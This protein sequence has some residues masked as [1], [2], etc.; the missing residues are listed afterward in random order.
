MDDKG[1]RIKYF[2]T[3]ECF[4]FRWSD[5]DALWT[6]RTNLKK[7]SSRFTKS[8]IEHF[9]WVQPDSEEEE[10]EEESSKNRRTRELF[11]S[12][13]PT[14]VTVGGGYEIQ[15]IKRS[16]LLILT[17]PQR[18][19]WHF[20]GRRPEIWENRELWHFPKPTTGL[21]KRLHCQ[22]DRSCWL[23]WCQLVNIWRM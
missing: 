16:A 5:Q 11:M 6:S 4:L 1:M 2:G 12:G 18:R 21:T 14:M 7:I 22:C 17:S 19:H 15:T 20:L 10:E 9:Q 8:G 13:D 3:G 23:Y